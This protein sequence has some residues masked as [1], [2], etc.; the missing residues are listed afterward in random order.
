MGAI[1]VA[2]ACG[3]GGGGTSEN[4]ASD[5]TL[6]FPIISDVGD[7]DPARMSAAVDIDLFQNVFSGLYKFNNKLEEVP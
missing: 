2:A 1:F 7:L 5:Q 3:G 4:L 6:S